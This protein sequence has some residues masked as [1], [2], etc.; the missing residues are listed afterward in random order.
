MCVQSALR[1]LAYGLHP[2][3]NSKIGEEFSL[4][5][6]VHIRGNI[7]TAVFTQM[8][9]TEFHVNGIDFI[10]GVPQII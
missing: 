1:F 4:F 2:L 9:F 10:C 8:S 5:L 6:L 3:V 7:K